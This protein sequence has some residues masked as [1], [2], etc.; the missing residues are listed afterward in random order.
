M[1]LQGPSEPARIAAAAERL[2]EELLELG[3]DRLPAAPPAAALPVS[4][5]VREAAAVTQAPAP[6]ADPLQ[7]L[8]AEVA[9][10]QLC[11]LCESRHR[12]V[13]GEGH[14]QARIV[15][16]GEAPGADEDQS[17]RPF[18]GAAGQL[19]TKIIT[20][21]MGLRRDEVFICNVLKCRPP[22]NRDPQPEEK[23]ACTPYLERQLRAIQPELVIALGRHAANHLL[24]REDSLGRL[25]GQLHSHAL[26]FPVLATYHPA[27]LLRSPAAK[28]DCWQDIQIGMRHLGLPLPPR[29][30]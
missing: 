25:R 20:Q 13:P 2:Y 5:P 27:Y 30:A 26:G 28:A 23:A 15:F 14:P 1:V 17:G 24:Q 21:G 10:C 9:A 29:Q 8:A 18:V 22:G 19:L 7:A 12:T 11:G 4:A 16:V 6:P 3:V